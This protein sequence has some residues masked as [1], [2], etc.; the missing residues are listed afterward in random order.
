MDTQL[1]VLE[2]EPP[3]SCSTGCCPEQKEDLPLNQLPTDQAES[4]TRVVQLT[5]PKHVTDTDLKLFMDIGALTMQVLA[6]GRMSIMFPSATKGDDGKV[7][8]QIGKAEVLLASTKDIENMISLV[9]AINTHNIAIANASRTMPPSAM[10]AENILA[11]REKNN[12]TR[13]AIA[14]VTGQRGIITP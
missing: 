11:N 13:N 1:P 7:Q 12:A 3:A 9:N 8:R 5:I 6:S 10:A 2:N 4:S 14:A